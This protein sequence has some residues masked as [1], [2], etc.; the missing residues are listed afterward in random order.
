MTIPIIDCNVGIGPWAFRVFPQHSAG[1]LKEVLSSLGVARAFAAATPAITCCD[2]HS[3]NE[4]FMHELQA[5]ASDYFLPLATINPTYPGWERDLASLAAQGFCGIKLYPN[6]H[7]YDI[8]GAEGIMAAEAAA[9]LNRPLFINMRLEDERHNHPLMKVPQ[10]HAD[11]L[12]ALAKK[13]PQA[14]IVMVCGSAGE[15][16]ICLDT[17]PPGAFFAEI[18]YVKSPLNGIEDLVAKVGHERLLFGTHLPFAD[19]R[20]ALAKVCEAAI[21]DEARAAILRHNAERLLPQ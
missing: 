19:P 9:A 20:T 4:P 15:M 1:A 21:S 6:Y 7:G 13:V 8:G 16:V 5:D 18:S 12:S 17:V 3:A 14:T 11:R 2:V 10:V